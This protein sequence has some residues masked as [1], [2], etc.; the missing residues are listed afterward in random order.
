VGIGK[1][2]NGTMIEQSGLHRSRQGSLIYTS[3]KITE[4]VAYR[5][6]D[7]RLRQHQVREMVHSGDTPMLQQ[8]VTEFVLVIRQAAAISFQVIGFRNFQFDIKQAH[9]VTAGKQCIRNE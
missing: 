3:R 2:V 5:R 4:E 7:G 8:P 9:Q 1:S 6:L